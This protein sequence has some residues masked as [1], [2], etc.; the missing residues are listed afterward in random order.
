MHGKYLVIEK[1]KVGK[2]GSYVK[3]SLRLRLRVR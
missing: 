1:E 3:V 2:S